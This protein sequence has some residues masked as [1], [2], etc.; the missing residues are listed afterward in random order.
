MQI[1]IELTEH[2]VAEALREYAERKV[3]LP[4]IEDQAHF[5]YEA[6]VTVNQVAHDRGQ[7]NYTTA[8][9]RFA[10]V[11]RPEDARG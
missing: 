4:A 3:K 9:V 6:K 1:A 8:T 2:E 7:G 10:L 5:K 11:R